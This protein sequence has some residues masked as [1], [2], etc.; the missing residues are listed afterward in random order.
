[1][2]RYQANFTPLSTSDA[3]VAAG[4]AG[5]ARLFLAFRLLVDYDTTLPGTYTLSFRYTLVVP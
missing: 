5:D 4:S 1:V 3:E 2:T